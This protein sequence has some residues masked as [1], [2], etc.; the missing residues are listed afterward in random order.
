[1]EN[2]LKKDDDWG[3]PMTQE[4]SIYHVLTEVVIPLMGHQKESP[5]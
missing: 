4:T 3:Y 2:R 1:M 5:P